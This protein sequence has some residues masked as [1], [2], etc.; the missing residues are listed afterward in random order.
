[1]IPPRGIQESWER[2]CSVYP[3]FN[4]HDYM[5]LYESMPQMIDDVMKSRGYW[6]NYLRFCR[7]FEQ[8]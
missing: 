3:N 8:N 1:M 2:V 4:E 5:M 7:Q 6:T